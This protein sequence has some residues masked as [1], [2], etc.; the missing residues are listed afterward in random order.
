MD[1]D[2]TT[3]SLTLDAGD[4]TTLEGLASEINRQLTMSGQFDG[5]RA[6]NAR[7]EDGYTATN[8]TVPTDANRYLILESAHGKSIQISGNAQTFFG[9]QYNTITGSDKILNSLG[10][11]A[12]SNDTAGQIDGGVDTTAD[13]GVVEVRI[14]GADGT[15][16]TRQVQLSSLD[17]SRSFSD[18]ANDLQTAVNDAF[19]GDGFSISASVTDGNFSIVMDQ[20]GSNTMSLSGTI[21]TDAFGS[22][23]SAT[24]TDAG[25]TLADMDAVA[26]AINVDL[27]AGGVDA[28]VSYDTEAATL[29]FTATSG[30]VGS[31]NSISIAGDDLAALEFGDTLSATGSNGNAT[32]DTIENIDISTAAGATSALDSIDNALG[33][34]NSQRANLGAIENRL[35]HTISN[36]TSVVVNTEASQSRIQDADFAAETSQ[37]TKAQVLSQAATSMLAQANASKQSVLSLLQG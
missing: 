33:Y 7:V 19:A 26:A 27:S 30:S 34:V 23:V 14:D 35:N 17:T 5:E 15:S 31:G 24:G 9:S 8:T 37:L 20:T 28:E 21:I 18:F 36:L 11:T 2:G 6:L 1:D 25:Q 12:Y 22:D 13:N 10:S 32:A 3:T 16:V 29:V 4:Y